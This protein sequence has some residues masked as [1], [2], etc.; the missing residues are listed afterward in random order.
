MKF[1]IFIVVLIVTIA[2]SCKKRFGCQPESFEYKF[3]SGKTIDTMRLG[4]SDPPFTYYGF[5]IKEGNSN[6]FTFKKFFRDC[7]EIA[8]DEGIMTIVFEAPS[9]TSFKIQDSLQL[10]QAKCLVSLQC[11][12]FPS[13]PVFIHHG[14]IEGKKLSENKWQ[15][16]LNLNMPWNNQ[17]FVTFDKTFTK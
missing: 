9:G 2:T 7:P 3:A 4:F 12:C 16:K 17:S 5:L 6:V 10:L 15:V 8:D 11:E 14:S 1:F 13:S